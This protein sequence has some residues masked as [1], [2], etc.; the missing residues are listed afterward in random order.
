MYRR[1]T[2]MFNGLAFVPYDERLFLVNTLRL[3]IRRLRFDLTTCYKIMKGSIDMVS[4]EF[5]LH[6]IVIIILAVVSLNYLFLTLE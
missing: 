5:F 3:E 6:L 1:F 2:K 4:N